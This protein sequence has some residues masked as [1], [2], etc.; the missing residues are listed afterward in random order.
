MFTTRKSLILKSIYVRNNDVSCFALTVISPRLHARV[1]R[2]LCQ[3][4][5]LR[6]STLRLHETLGTGRTFE[7]LSAQVWDLK[8]AGQL[9]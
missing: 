4:K 6:S 2:K 3:D 7:R 9:F 5:I 1:R 8:K